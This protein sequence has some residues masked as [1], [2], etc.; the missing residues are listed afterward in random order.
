MKK[1][2]VVLDTNV[3]ISGIIFGGIPGKSLRKALREYQ[4][5]V[6]S[7]ILAEYREVPLVLKRKGKITEE[8][9]NALI[10]GIA[11]FVSR[12]EIFFPKENLNICPHREDNILLECCLEA[13]A[14]FLITGDK[15]LLQIP[16]DRIKKELPW[17]KII[18]PSEFIIL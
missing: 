7:H 16:E 17:L 15:D 14:H 18:S 3:L 2:K 6:S 8:Q 11:S 4:I 5:C 12:A 13:N 1:K 10:L 9:L